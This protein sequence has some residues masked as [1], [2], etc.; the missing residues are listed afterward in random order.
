MSYFGEK[1]KTFL[2][3]VKDSPSTD[4]KRLSPAEE[5]SDPK[6]SDSIGLQHHSFKVA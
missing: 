4:P 1:V 6:N 3:C 2:I 5:G